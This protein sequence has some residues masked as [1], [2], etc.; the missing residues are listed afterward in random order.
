[1]WKS[2]NTKKYKKKIN[3]PVKNELSLFYNIGKCHFC[4]TTPVDWKNNYKQKCNK[5][6]LY[7]KRLKMKS[8]KSDCFLFKLIIH[9]CTNYTEID[10]YTCSDHY[11]M[12]SLFQ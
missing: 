4:T 9:T 7:W 2:W 12:L 3:K 8:Y 1:M 5:C 6:L 11:V 10:M